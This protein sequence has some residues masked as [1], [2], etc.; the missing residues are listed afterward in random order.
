MGVRRVTLN[1]TAVVLASLTA[2]GCS[3]TFESGFASID[4]QERTVAIVDAASA[5]DQDA[6][7]HLISLL[8]SDD[9]AERMLADQSLRQ[10]TGQDFGYHFYDPDWRRAK[11]ARAWSE[12][13]QSQA[14]QSSS[15]STSTTP[16]VHPPSADNTGSSPTP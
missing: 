2:A 16:I 14:G 1:L 6:I 5:G 11:A 3:P 4:P 9:P 10:L 13:W 15:A 7:P 8:D 12:W